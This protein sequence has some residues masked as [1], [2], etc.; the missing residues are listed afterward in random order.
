MH[1]PELSVTAAGKWPPL[2]DTGGVRDI[3][4]R[5]SRT[6]VARMDDMRSVSTG[7]EEDEEVVWCDGMLD[8][9]TWSREESER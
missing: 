9:G 1:G 8:R 4:M 3:V 6:T 2:A 5:S 7:L